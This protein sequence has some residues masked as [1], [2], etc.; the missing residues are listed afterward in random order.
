MCPIRVQLLHGDITVMQADVCVSSIHRSKNMAMG[1]LSK[2]LLTSG[3]KTIQNELFMKSPAG[4]LKIGQVETVSPGKLKNFKELLFVC[5]FTY[6][7]GNEEILQQ[8]ILE[9][10][11]LAAVKK[12][13]S[14][15]FPALGTGLDYPPERVAACILE[16]I[17]MHNYQYPDSSLHI[18]YIVLLD[19]DREL[20]QAFLFMYMKG[21]TQLHGDSSS[22]SGT[23]KDVDKDLLAG[24]SYTSAQDYFNEN[25][26]PQGAAG[27]SKTQKPKWA[28]ASKPGT[29]GPKQAMNPTF[30]KFM[31]AIGSLFSN[32]G[33]SLQYGNVTCNVRPQV[34]PKV[35]GVQLSFGID[36]SFIDK[37]V[38]PKLRKF[39]QGLAN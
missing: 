15:A 3:G 18:A 16:S 38:P 1:K 11:E 22:K 39:F 4:D 28:K 36:V 26:S 8:S 14:I 31:T 19:R 27:P 17:A 23:A 30:H 12:Y 13:K 10:L 25:I 9:C 24:L 33:W 29:A 34:S 6:I 5:L 35:I 37:F 7:P 21:S 2:H 32:T 20:I